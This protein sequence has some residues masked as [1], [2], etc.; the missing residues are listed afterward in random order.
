MRVDVI[1]LLIEYIEVDT[2]GNN[3]DTIIDGLEVENLE[4]DITLETWL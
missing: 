2:Q 1:D 4:N 3:I